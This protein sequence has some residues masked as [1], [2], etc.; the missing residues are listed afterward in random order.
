MGIAL[1]GIKNITE[2]NKF[3]EFGRVRAEKFNYGIQV[4][5]RM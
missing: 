4:F 5:T 3:A 2:L 1:P